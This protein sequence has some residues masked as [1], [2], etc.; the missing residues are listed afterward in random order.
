MSVR[1]KSYYFLSILCTI[2]CIFSCQR[3][4]AQKQ[5]TPQN[6]AFLELQNMYG[7]IDP[8]Q[9][10]YL[11]NKRRATMME[12]QL[13]Q[14]VYPE[15][16]NLQLLYIKE[17]LR[18][19][20][21]EEALQ[22]VDQINS[23]LT[24]RNINLPSDIKQKFLLLHATIYLRQGEL[25]NCL[26]NHQMSSCILPFDQ[27][28]EHINPGGSEA[29]IPIL[30][31]V[32][33][34]N[35]E[36]YG[37]IWL[38]NIA[39]ETLGKSRSDLQAAFR[40]P[41]DAD[42]QERWANKSGSMGIDFNGLAGG[43]IADDFNNDGYIDLVISSWGES[44]GLK[45]YEHNTT[46]GFIDKSA[47]SGLSKIF[48]GLNINH[49]DY[50]NDGHLDIFV[51]RGGWFETQGK[52][53]NSL[54]KNN[55][56]GSFTDVTKEAGIYTLAPTQAS[57]WTD[58]NQDGH[59]DLFV[60][61]ESSER[62]QFDNELWIND[63]QGHFVNKIAGS[64][65]DVHGFFKGVTAVCLTENS[66]IAD[67]FLSDYKGVNRIFKNISSQQSI[68]FSALEAPW[69]VDKPL[70]S[71][72]CW[73]FDQDND[74]LEDIFVSGYGNS[75]GSMSPISSAGANYTGQYVGASPIIYRN[76]AKGFQSLDQKSGL[77]K[78][79]YT[80]GSNFGDLDND[81]A[82]DFYLA[83]GDPAMASIV[84]NLVYQNEGN[85]QYKDVSFQLGMAHLQKGHGVAF[86]DF[87][88]DGDQDIYTV[89]GG[90][91]EGDVFANA[92]FENPGSEHPWIV[93]HLRGKQ[94]NRAAIGAR[95]VLKYSDA[96][97]NTKQIHRK[98]TSGSS[99]GGN[100]LQLEI[101]LGSAEK[102]LECTVIWPYKDSVDQF[103]GLEINKA[104][105]L[106]EGGQLEN[107]GYQPIQFAEKQQ[108]HH[109]H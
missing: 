18:S 39:Y 38:L 87:D 72:S 63:G 46:D 93:L 91:Y 21:I 50:N 62:A 6:D 94:S 19:N 81:G 86:A 108:H 4:D 100:S 42:E 69:K 3:E 7:Q 76:T 31:E 75:D 67:I 70:A 60:A 89:L 88:R 106:T 61:N 30:K 44:D 98:V 27:A 33:T 23:V 68:Q 77:D 96:A 49:T 82:L 66:S 24:Q 102:I 9:I 56:D 80:M 48:G 29:A 43:V 78:A 107:M 11:F 28:A 103:E 37:A 32:L 20:R 16:L 12:G 14:M 40:I 101:G 74:G 104:Y 47:S 95:V 53:P 1:Q 99:F 97:G 90:A 55:G 92:Y 85:N 57:V 26:E 25:E 79:A 34:L 58:I 65:L 73:A 13:Q 59:I 15:K 51:M 83:T 2:L 8:T 54:L 22:N 84:P 105:I 17:L 45:Y 109:H 41:L 10:D 64:G 5:A 52:L 36:N 35:P 71:F